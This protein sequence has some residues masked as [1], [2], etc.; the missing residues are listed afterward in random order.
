MM[1]V[2]HHPA[3]PL[4]VFENGTNAD[5]TLIDGVKS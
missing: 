2:S 3:E 4:G 1:L 5:L